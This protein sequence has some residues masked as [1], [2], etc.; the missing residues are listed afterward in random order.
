M[1]DLIPIAEPAE[2]RLNVV[3]VHG[4][5]GDAWKTWALDG[6]EENFWPKHL[7]GAVSGLGVY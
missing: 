2:R 1:A 6:E 5:G 4:L 7:A 3:F